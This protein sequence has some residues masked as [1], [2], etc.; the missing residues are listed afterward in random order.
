MSKRRKEHKHK[1][2]KDPSGTN[3]HTLVQPLVCYAFQLL[4]KGSSATN[5]WKHDDYLGKLEN[6]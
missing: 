2:K 3:E 1:R 4:D 5:T 6:S